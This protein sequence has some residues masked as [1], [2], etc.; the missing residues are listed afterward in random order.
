MSAFHIASRP[1]ANSV[2]EAAI[3]G[4]HDAK[5]RAFAP[6]TETTG[7]WIGRLRSGRGKRAIGSSARTLKQKSEPLR[8]LRQDW[9][10]VFQLG[11]E[12]AVRLMK[13][14]FLDSAV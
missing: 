3:E 7:R 14:E 5:R 4:S 8:F 10:R 1:A 11:N 12:G 13:A 6:G 2:C 9:L